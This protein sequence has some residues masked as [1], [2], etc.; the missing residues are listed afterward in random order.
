MTIHDLEAAKIRR[1]KTLLIKKNVV[2]LKFLIGI[3]NAGSNALGVEKKHLKNLTHKF[4]HV[5][6]RP[7]V[8][9]SL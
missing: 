6:C 5:I 7:V 2:I 3:G 4:M 9:K 1:K 8:C